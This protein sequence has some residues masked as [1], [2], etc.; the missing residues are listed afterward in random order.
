LN[1]SE[2]SAMNIINRCTTK[3]ALKRKHSAGYVWRTL[4]YGVR[5]N[6]IRI[7]NAGTLGSSKE[8]AVKKCRICGEEQLLS[9]FYIKYN[10]N[11]TRDDC[12]ICWDKYNG[13]KPDNETFAS[14]ELRSDDSW[15]NIQIVKLKKKRKAKEKVEPSTGI[16]VTIFI[17]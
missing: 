4:P 8:L 5:V 16:D 12:V 15:A 10:P 3:P 2:L 17:K 11:T 1:P 9:N 6:T 13:A 14:I 7:D